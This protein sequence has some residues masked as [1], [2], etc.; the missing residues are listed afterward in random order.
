MSAAALMSL[1][2]A[3]AASPCAAFANAPGRVGPMLARPAAVC[4][5]LKFA[6]RPAPR[7]AAMGKSTLKMAVN[8][9]MKPVNAKAT[10]H[11][12]ATGRDPRRVK[13]FDTTL[14][15]GEQS[16]GCSMTSEEK[17]QVAKQLHKLGV[18]VIEAGYAAPSKGL[19]L[20]SMLFHEAGTCA[21]AHAWAF[22]LV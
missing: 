6:L 3:M 7:A 2:M 18:D 14:R 9:E 1:P 16:P 22:S 10:A 11:D 8:G 12:I 19:C 15:D 21:G 17:L 13:V 5:P 4:K 20:R